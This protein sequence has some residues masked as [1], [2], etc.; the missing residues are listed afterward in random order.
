MYQGDQAYNTLQP[1]TKD[2]RKIHK[3]KQSRFSYGKYFS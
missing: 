1:W 3:I 2:C